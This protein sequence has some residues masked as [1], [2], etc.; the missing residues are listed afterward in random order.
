MAICPLSRV[1]RWSQ[2]QKLDVIGGGYGSSMRESFCH[3]ARKVHVRHR[4][5]TKCRSAWSEDDRK[6]VP[7]QIAC[8]GFGNRL[9]WQW[10]SLALPLA[11]TC[12]GLGHSEG[13]PPR[14]EVT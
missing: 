1:G 14:H 4:L 9:H 5:S 3:K 11:T 10:Q 12:T 13:N 6:H 2:V 8:I 7:F